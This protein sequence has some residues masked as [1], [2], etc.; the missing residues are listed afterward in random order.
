MIVKEFITKLDN[1]DIFLY[2]MKNAYGAEMKITNY[3]AI[4]ASIRMP[5]KKGEFDEVVLGYDDVNT[6][7]ENNPYYFGCVVGRYANRIKDGKFVLNGKTYQ[8]NRNEG[9]NHLHGGV[10]GFHQKVWTGKIENDELILS[11]T[12]PDGEEKFPG[13]VEIDIK[14][15]L[16]EDNIVEIRYEAKSDA[17]T[18]INLTNHS[19][20]NLNGAKSRVLD[21]YLM[22]DADYFIPTDKELIPTGELRHV[23]GTPFDF[24]K[25]HKISDHVFDYAYEAIDIG[26]GYD[27]TMVFNGKG[28][29]KAAELYDE[30][31]GRCME[32]V[33]DQPSAQLFTAHIIR[34]GTQGLGG[35]VYG[36]YYGVCIEPQVYPNSPNVEHFPDCVLR[37]GDVYKNMARY[38]FSVK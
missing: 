32:V 23:E 11:Y 10:S 3:G 4:V 20:F 8:L 12:S 24:R 34:E 25:M 28:M 35:K 31:S 29:R 14:Y 5:D 18:I 27:H 21:H 19:Y 37:K 26:R 2:R 7:I 36:Q 17:D 38:A 30:A 16:T 13:N 6:Y 33:T 15:T 9:K 1:E 22:M